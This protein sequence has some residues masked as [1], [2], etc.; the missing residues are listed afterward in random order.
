MIERWLPRRT[1][2]LVLLAVWLLAFDGISAGLVLLGV[3]VAVAIPLLTREFWPDY[4]AIRNQMVLWRLLAVFVWDIVVANLTVARQ[5][6]GPANRL[7]PGF[8]IVPVEIEQPLVA[9]LF[10]SMISLTPGTVSSNLSGDRSLLLV[11]KLDLDPAETDAVIAEI[12]ARYE[13][14]L[15]EVFAC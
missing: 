10:T 4:P 13:A 8:I 9:A 14:P 7:R 11:H 6:L 3:L 1:L 5:I 15:K 12:K 2:S